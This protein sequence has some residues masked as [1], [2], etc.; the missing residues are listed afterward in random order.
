VSTAA[1]DGVCTL[2]V[3]VVAF[4]TRRAGDDNPAP[5]TPRNALGT[6]LHQMASS[7]AN[8]QGAGCQQVTAAL[9]ATS[10]NVLHSDTIRRTPHAHVAHSDPELACIC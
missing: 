3:G 4:A 10:S 1:V 5:A 8:T 6:P 9:T 2:A 7:Q